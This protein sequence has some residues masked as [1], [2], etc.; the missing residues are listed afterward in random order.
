MQSGCNMTGANPARLLTLGLTLSLAGPL[1]CAA[2]KDAGRKGLI[3]GSFLSET[4]I[5]RVADLMARDMVRSPIFHDTRSPPR[6]ALVK[7]ENNT[8]QYFFG[9]ARDAYLNRMRTQL[10][11]ALRDRIKLIDL[12]AEQTLRDELA[13]WYLDEATAVE[14]ARGTKA[15]HGVDYLLTGMFSSLD[16]V[17]RV[18]DKKGNLNNR[19]IVEL[20]MVFSLVDAE[21]GELAW[22]NDVTSAAA[23]TTRDFQN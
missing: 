15:R 2:P 19:R 20:M 6:V 13:G 21:T 18:A 22:Q 1:G 5:G 9:G 12:E 4:E 11:R 14:M 16:K 3:T 10:K 23:F 17:V 7:V 8:N